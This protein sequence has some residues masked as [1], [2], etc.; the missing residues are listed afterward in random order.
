MGSSIKIGLVTATLAMKRL[1]A[2]ERKH[3]LSVAMDELGHIERTLFMLRWLR[4]PQQRYRTFVAL[5]KIERRNTMADA[6]FIHR[7]ST[8]KDRTLQDLLN[9]AS[10]LNLLIMALVIWNTR[11]LAHT[12]EVL[13]E[14]AIQTPEHLL[15][16][17][18]PLAWEHVNLTGDFNWDKLLPNRDGL[19]QLRETKIASRFLKQPAW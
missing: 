8:V 2:Y 16:H 1:A 13:R 19:R 9:R 4:D 12:I 5:Q 10:G 14:R 11:Y 18:S 7:H 6:L 17:I 3:A 15:P